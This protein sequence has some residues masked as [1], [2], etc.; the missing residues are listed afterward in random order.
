MRLL[1][2][3]VIA[4]LLVQISG[5]DSWAICRDNLSVREHLDNKIAYVEKQTFETWYNRTASSHVAR[6]EGA[7]LANLRSMAELPNPVSVCN[8]IGTCACAFKKFGA[9]RPIRH[10]K[11]SLVMY[12]DHQAFEKR[13]RGGGSSR[14][15]SR[16][17]MWQRGGGTSRSKPLKT[18][19]RVGFAWLQHDF[20]DIK[21]AVLRMQHNMSAALDA[22]FSRRAERHGGIG[23]DSDGKV[24]VVNPLVLSE[25]FYRLVVAHEGLVETIQGYLGPNARLDDAFLQR[26]NPRPMTPDGG[27][28]WKSSA[29]WHHDTVGHRLKMFVYLSDVDASTATPIAAGTHRLLYKAGYHGEFQGAEQDNGLSRFDHKYVEETFDVRSMV[30]SPGDIFLFD[31]NSIHR[32]AA[33]T[34]GRTARETLVLEFSNQELSQDVRRGC[35]SHSPTGALNY[36]RKRY[37]AKCMS[38]R[39]RLW[40]W[41][42]PRTFERAAGELSNPDIM[43]SEPGYFEGFNRG[44]LLPALL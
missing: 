2:Y 7:A 8:E 11:C 40:K 28:P 9:F 15:K 32:A 19:F 22:E 12:Q 23:T 10:D 5:R 24:V 35:S 38:K 1:F 42:V 26:N 43:S 29:H 20:P 3:W 33:L 18:M 25:E 36:S 37:E 13:Q 4:R 30:G 21:L 31:T 27:D 34:G 39:C 16:K 44:R 14:S 17:T 41:L 6:V